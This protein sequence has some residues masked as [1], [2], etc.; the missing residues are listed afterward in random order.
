V[1]RD[2]ISDF[3]P[4]QQHS[5]EPYAN[6]QS[7]G[8]PGWFSGAAELQ[9][10]IHAGDL[11]WDAAIQRIAEQ[12]CRVAGADGAAIGLLEADQLV[13][14]AGAGSAATYAGRHMV[15]TLCGLAPQDATEILR[16]EDAD[17]D[18]RIQAAICR[19]FGA[20]SLLILPI[21]NEAALAGVLQ[22]FFSHPHE[23]AEDETRVY[24]LLAGMVAD[25]MAPFQNPAH[26]QML[27]TAPGVPGVVVMH[28]PGASGEPFAPR[29]ESG[30]EERGLRSA[31]QDLA[32]EPP[33]PAL[34]QSPA[35]FG[36]WMKAV[37][38]P[39]LRRAWDLGIA[40]T[41]LATVI[42]LVLCGDRQTTQ[43][44]LT[45]T[46][47]GPDIVQPQAAPAS[48]RQETSGPVEDS[49]PIS[50]SV[51]RAVPSQARRSPRSPGVKTFG[52][53]VTVRYFAPRSTALQS[54]GAGVRRLSD[55]VTIRYFKPRAD[56]S[57]Q[58]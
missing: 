54:S 55:D 49:V 8:L 53:D 58:P 22:I 27:S 44:S 3:G 52:D 10:A 25:A 38:F 46:A 12:A 40:A 32:A 35:P 37:G 36:T 6:R 1:N 48:G 31:R 17:A 28:G 13:Y 43:S 30:I 51:P 39:L 19:Q 57:Q 5:P 7:N 26:A 21:H 23:F 50:A 18:P 11:A 33:T 41:A 4:L 20:R 16:V 9:R 14:R 47:A 24:Q 56:G 15:A 2:P 42:V 45:G 29:T 34:G